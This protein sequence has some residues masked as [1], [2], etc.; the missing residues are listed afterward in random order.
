[1]AKVKKF[2][3]NL[4]GL[5]LNIVD[6][7]P[8]NFGSA[9]VIPEI[10]GLAAGQF[11]TAMG[12]RYD[13]AAEK[14]DEAEVRR[15]MQT[16]GQFGR[17]TRVD[18]NGFHKNWERHDLI[19][20]V[21]HEQG[22][23]VVAMIGY[24]EMALMPEYSRRVIERYGVQRGGP[25]VIAE[26]GN[27]QNSTSSFSKWGKP[28]PE[29][30]AYMAIKSSKAI[31]S[32][33]RTLR[34]ITGGLSPAADGNGS[35]EIAPVTYARRMF[36]AMGMAGMRYFDGWGVHPYAWDVP[37]GYDSPYSAWGQMQHG[38]N[39]YDGQTQTMAQV[40]A[41]A[42]AQVRLYITEFGAP[43]RGDGNVVSLERQEEDADMF[44]RSKFPGIVTPVRLWHT[45][46]DVRDDT[47]IEGGFGLIDEKGQEK[48]AGT[49]IR[50]TLS[51]A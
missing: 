47:S 38:P 49:L 37:G 3:S 40:M 22:I 11:G 31:R 24:L 12:D 39:T 9:L 44:L 29:A 25:V 18:F 14:G 33:N 26:L 6:S 48:P 4:R 13:D 35:G 19:M 2:S 42:G 45:V 23:N 43:T 10:P 5:R 1:M 16:A 7:P 36:K 34:I 51:S 28:D 32:V 50:T 21:A 27:E 8:P 46:F 30:Y 41:Q 17:L 20:R 15:R